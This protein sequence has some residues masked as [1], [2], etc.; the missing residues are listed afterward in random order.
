MKEYSRKDA[1]EYRSERNLGRDVDIYLAT[2]KEK[3][4]KR[5][6]MLAIFLSFMFMMI[7]LCG[8]TEEQRVVGIVLTFLTSGVGI[9]A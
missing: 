8:R 4:R 5:D 1:F 3:Y 7:A 2:K 9:Y 6:R